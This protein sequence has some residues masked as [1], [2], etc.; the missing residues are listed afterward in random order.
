MQKRYLD[1]PQQRRLLRAAK[2]CNDPLAQRDYHW[3]AA[4]TL[5]GMRIQE[6]SKLTAQRVR[7]GLA[8]GWLVSLKDNCKG[9]RRAN[10]YMVTQQLRVHLQALLKLSD[11]LAAGIELCDGQE[12]PLVWG[13]DI[14]GKAGPLSVR[15]YELRIKH[16]AEAAGLDPRLSPHWLRHTRGMNIMRR[17]RGDNPLKVCQL[18]LNHASMAST[19]VYLQMSREE[20][21]RELQLVDGTRLPKKVA[22]VL[23]Q[24]VAA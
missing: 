9:K 13:R 11:D 12:Q 8:C 4:L 15:S 19:G 5:S 10:E 22:R 6:F 17:S 14:A 3:M 21:E 20:Y 7:L 2:C 1:E 24:G 16:W 18:A 23:A